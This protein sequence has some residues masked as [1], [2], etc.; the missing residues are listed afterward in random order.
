MENKKQLESAKGIVFGLYPTGTSDGKALRGLPLQKINVSVH[1]SSSTARVIFEQT[2]LNNTGKLLEVEY[3]FPIPT[4][5]A[6]D[7]FATKYENT[8]IQGVIKK[9]ETAQEEYK[10]SLDEYKT[11]AY[12]EIDEATGD[13]M[14]VKVGN[15]KPSTSIEIVFSYI[16]RLEVVHNQFYRFAFLSTLTPRYG[17]KKN[18]E[19]EDEDIGLLCGYPM[20]PPKMGYSW[21]L[22]AVVESKSPITMIECTSHPIKIDEKG[23]PYRKEVELSSSSD[24]TVF[25]EDFVLYYKTE[26]FNKP[27]YRLAKNENGFCAMIDF[28]PKFSDIVLDEDALYAALEE[29]ANLFT[30]TGEYIF[31]IDRSG[32]MGGGRIQMAKTALLFALKSLPPNSYFNVLSFGSH[33]DKLYPESRESSES[34]ITEAMKLI[35]KFDADMGGTEIL[36]PLLTVMTAERLKKH[37]RSI[38]LLTDGA[39]SNTK[40]I[41]DQILLYNQ[42]NRV[43]ALGIGNGCSNA[44]VQGCADRGKGKAAFVTNASEIP[45]AVVSLIEASVNS[46]CDDFS[47]EFSDAAKS[48][49]LMIAP[50]PSAQKFIL[51]NEIVSFFVFFSNQVLEQGSSV[52]VTLRCFDSFTDDYTTNPMKI[53]LKNYETTLDIFKLGIAKAADTLAKQEGSLPKE[54]PDVYWAGKNS[55]K[56]DLLAMSITNQVLTKETA[57]ICVAKENSKDELKGLQKTKEIIPQVLSLDYIPTPVRVQVSTSKTGKHGHAKKMVSYGGHSF[58]L[59]D[60]SPQDDDEKGKPALFEKDFLKLVDSQK[61]LGY[62][63]M[64]QDLIKLLKINKESLLSEIIVLIKKEI[65]DVLLETI[66]VTIAVLAWIEKYQ[67]PQKASWVLIHKKGQQW[68]A[69]QGVKYSEAATAIN[70]LI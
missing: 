49:I 9:K 61:S 30:A 47:L 40:A 58:F 20:L 51:K 55:I 19:A 4:G 31:L 62:W 26:E 6:F 8:T 34:N 38:F 68:L 63:E 48:S 54:V 42:R 21:G 27:T 17:S 36:R 32:S 7:S 11:A 60:E 24:R 53:D 44:L 64:D 16:Q 52:D 56:E 14:K 70:V 23:D 67:Q 35:Q 50:E 10:K 2:Y 46:V 1:I 29:D 15:I 5:V 33:Y 45:G 57:F 22:K 41:H 39:V 65:D 25:N 3:Y 43:F 69:A 59:V 18:N 12:A 13:V 66:A 28:V 37:P